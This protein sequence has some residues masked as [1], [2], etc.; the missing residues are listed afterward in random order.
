MK[1]ITLFSTLIILLFAC[2]EK[3]SGHNSSIS[4]NLT[5]L[6]EGDKIYL[7]YFTPTQQDTKDTAIIDE[8]GNYQ[9]NYIIEKQG[10]YRLRLNNQNFITL[11]FE[12]G[13]KPIINGEGKNLMDSYTIDGSEESSRFR[14]FNLA[15]RANAMSQDSLQR[16]YQANPNDQNLFINLQQAKFGAINKM[17][18]VFIKIINENPNSLVSLEA[19]KQLDSKTNSELYKKVDEAMEKSFSDNPWFMDFH[20]KVKSMVLLTIG[21][22]APDFTLNDSKGNPI[23]LSSLR[24]KIVLIDFWASWCRP[25]RAENPNVVKA[26]NKYNKQGF[27]VMSVSL[28]GMPRQQNAKQDWLEAIKKDGLI[29]KNHVSELKGWSSSIVPIY[30]VQSIPFTVLIDKEGIILGKNLRGEELEKKIAENF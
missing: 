5:N 11:V 12:V 21:K 29:W 9:F 3:Q 27:D 15:Y 30:G 25:C 13:D 24:G 10:F 8:K 14:A 19:V 6:N 18:G 23:S 17:N 7:D 4:G 1:N 28:D 26:Y 22:L 2:G 20:K 16:V